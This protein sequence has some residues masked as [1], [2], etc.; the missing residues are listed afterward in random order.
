VKR[1]IMFNPFHLSHLT[2]VSGTELFHNMD[3]C[4]E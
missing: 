4:F 2:F 1:E 3:G